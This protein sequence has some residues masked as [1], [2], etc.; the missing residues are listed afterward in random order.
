[1]FA[2]AESDERYGRYYEQV[3][4]IYSEMEG[5]LRKEKEEFIG[6]IR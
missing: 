5:L 2:P 6:R 3:E 4:S 1:M